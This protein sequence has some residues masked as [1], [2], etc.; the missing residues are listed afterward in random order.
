MKYTLDTQIEINEETWRVASYRKKYGKELIYTLQHEEVDGRYKTME[1]NENALTKIIESGSKVYC[2][3][4]EWDIK[5]GS[6]VKM[7]VEPSIKT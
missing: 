5:D 3:T 4:T 7:I 2:T 1:L 6:K